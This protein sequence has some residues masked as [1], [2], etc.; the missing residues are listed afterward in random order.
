MLRGALGSRRADARASSCELRSPAMAPA[1]PPAASF[2]AAEVQRRLAAGDCWVRCGARLYDLTG[3][4]RHHPGGEQ[5]LRARAGQ[6]VSADLDGPPHRHSANARRWL[7]QYYVGDLLGDPQV[8]P[9]RGSHT[10]HLPPPSPNFLLP[11][12][13]RSP[14]L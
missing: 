8:Q 9:V 1:P 11:S 13:P 6:D 12:Q 2:S 7:E 3:F 5:L 10:F 4:V 14:A